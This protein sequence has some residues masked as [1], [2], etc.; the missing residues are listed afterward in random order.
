MPEGVWELSLGTTGNSHVVLPNLHPQAQDRGPAPQ[1]AQQL[2]RRRQDWLAKPRNSRTAG[3]SDSRTV[4]QPDSP[5]ADPVHPAAGAM[6]QAG[7]NEHIK[8]QPCGFSP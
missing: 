6:S 5:G 4:G 7:L 8:N 3:Q 1:A 2:K